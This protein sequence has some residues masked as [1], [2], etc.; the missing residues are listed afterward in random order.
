[1]QSGRGGGI[2]RRGGTRGE[3]AQAP[4]MLAEKEKEDFA[5]GYGCSLVWWEGRCETAKECRLRRGRSSRERW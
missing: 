3:E 2:W 5:L 4:K 1:M